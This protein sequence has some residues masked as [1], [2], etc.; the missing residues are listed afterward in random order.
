MCPELSIGKLPH[1][2]LPR[3]QK[4]VRTLVTFGGTLLPSRVTHPALGTTHIT[5]HWVFKLPDA[6]CVKQKW[7][8]MSGMGFPLC[9]NGMF[10][11][12]G[13]R[14]VQP[15]SPEGCLGFLWGVDSSPGALSLHC[16]YRHG[17]GKGFVD[18]SRGLDTDS[19][20]RLQ[21]WVL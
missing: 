10:C 7:F 5:F 16:P 18:Q 15:C 8:Q 20:H 2:L 21:W 11:F 14:Q 19:E 1:L 6:V 9:R 3:K 12:Q 13:L 17:F 4:V